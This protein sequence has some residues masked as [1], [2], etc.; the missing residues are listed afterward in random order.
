VAGNPASPIR[1][2]FASAIVENLLALGIYQWKKEKFEVLKPLLCANDFD[3]LTAASA[4]YDQ[5]AAKA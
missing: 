5:G 2:R 3:A 4:Q 1:Q